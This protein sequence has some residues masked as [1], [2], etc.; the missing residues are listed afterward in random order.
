MAGSKGSSESEESESMSEQELEQLLA[1]TV[2]QMHLDMRSEME[3]GGLADGPDEYATLFETEPGTWKQTLGKALQDGLTPE[4]ID[5]VYARGEEF[6]NL[7]RFKEAETLFT[8]YSVMAPTD[9]RGMGGLAAIYLEKKEYLRALD[10]LN[11]L[12]G[13][14][15]SNLDETF[16]NSA[17]CYYKL[18]RHQ[19]ASAALVMVDEAK[20]PGGEFYAKRYGYLKQQ[21]N[22]H[23]GDYFRASH[24]DKGAI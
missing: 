4:D 8:L 3:A 23:L 16:L 9:H 21:L 7:F 6:Y 10:M 15:T 14:P 13:L 12:R 5:R 1:Q 11:V 20:L 24:A 2:E 17:L 22:K 18:D 19:E